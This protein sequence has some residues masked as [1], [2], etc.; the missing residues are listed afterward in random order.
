MFLMTY[1]T[2]SGRTEQ[3]KEKALWDIV[4]ILAGIEIIFFPVAGTVLCF[5]FRNNVDNTLMLWFVTKSCLVYIEDFSV[6][7]VLGGSMAREAG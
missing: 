1:E 6:F 5:G 7:H 3:A 4:L 2:F